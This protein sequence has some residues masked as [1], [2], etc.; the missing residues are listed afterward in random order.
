MAPT[1]EELELTTQ[2]AHLNA[3]QLQLAQRAADWADIGAWC[4]DGIRSCEHW[5]TI[6]TGCDLRT[7]AEYIR[8]GRALRDLPLL[9]DAGTTGSL[10]FDKMRH[11]IRVAT[12]ADEQLWIDVARAATGTQLARI[13]RGFQ[14]VT[15]SRTSEDLRRAARGLWANW[16]EDGLVHIRAV[17]PT[18][19]AELLLRTIEG[20]AHLD[21]KHP[22]DEPS[23]AEQAEDPSA[24]RRI[25]AL[26]HLVHGDTPPAPPQ[27][28]VHVDLDLLEAHT[29]AGHAI[30]PAVA[31]RLGCDASVVAVTERDGTPLDVGK[32]RRLP[33]APLR[34]A[35]HSRD[36]TCRFPGC[37]VPAKST[38]SH[39]IQHWA[40]GG[41][42][43][44]DNL[45]SLCGHHHRRLHDGDYGIEQ[46]DGSLTFIT[47]DHRPIGGDAATVTAQ[48]A[49]THL[50]SIAPA[51]GPPD[52]PRATDGGA[53]CDYE[54]GIAV[55]VGAAIEQREQ[56]A[57][58]APRS[59]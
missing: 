17:L 29:D 2:F 41:E 40:D 46:R 55:I 36:R 53:H 31:R 51:A 34:R 24:A 19:D 38:H 8:V 45:V 44:L 42:T 22:T 16:S 57:R 50:H 28:V 4:G 37:G 20:R 25:D 15:A 43:T 18:E 14:R 59:P 33:S 52:T 3:A 48:P 35:L 32:A 5:L 13:C 54:Y 6:N 26:L 11:I 23:D 58:A 49:I 12:A 21:S 9:R 7:A 30:L 1:P 39:H 10:S 56:A 27:L 47:T